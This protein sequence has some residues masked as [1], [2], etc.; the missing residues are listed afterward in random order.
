MV[1]PGWLPKALTLADMWEKDLPVINAVLDRDFRNGSPEF[2]HLP[3][4]WDRSIR[5]E[6]GLEDGLWHLISR[7]GEMTI[8][9]GYDVARANKV[10]WCA[11]CLFFQGESVCTVWQYG[12]RGR[13][14]TYVWVKPLDYCIV[15][16]VREQRKGRIAW[17]VTAYHVDGTSRR[18]NLQ[19][20]WDKRIQ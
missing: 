2:D 12:E 1:W 14:R 19:R 20:K 5:G 7:E 6:H 4:W 3:V 18:R 16:E 15:L 10:P 11:P 8:V 13:V 17:L 9:R